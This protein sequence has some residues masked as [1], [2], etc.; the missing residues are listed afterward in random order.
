MAEPGKRRQFAKTPGEA[1]FTL[2]EM[3]VAV[4]IFAIIGAMSYGTL[5]HFLSTRDALDARNQEITRLH[6]AIA[7]FERDVRFMVPRPVRD[8]FGDALPALMSISEGPATRGDLMELTVS[9]PSYRNPQWR[10]L[11]RVGWR[12]DEGRLIRRAW[13]VLDRDID[14]EPRETT[15]LEGVASVELIYYERDAD[16]RTIESRR[17]WEQ[18]RSQPLGIELILT[19]TDD[20]TYRRVL[21]VS[22]GA[23]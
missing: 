19:L 4:A 16:R 22:G 9:L 18:E 7:Q 11:Q 1:G 8:R 15:L 17:L 20:R 12:L 6:R 3:V 2:L 5:D 23:F 10:R 13:A 14:S 21:E